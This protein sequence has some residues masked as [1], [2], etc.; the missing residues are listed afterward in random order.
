MRISSQINFQI[1]FGKDWPSKVFFE[2]TKSTH[3][4][5]IREQ[6]FEHDYVCFL[7]YTQTK[8]VLHIDFYKGKKYS[9]YYNKKT[10]QS[11]LISIE[12]E[13][14]SFPFATYGEDFIFVKYNETIG[15]PT[16]VFYK[17]DFDL[18]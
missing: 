7:N 15:A 5:M 17:I 8:N 3:P 13:N 1:D 11:L 9:I 16:L 4:L 14:I 10:K 2:N 18:Q 6:M 12:D